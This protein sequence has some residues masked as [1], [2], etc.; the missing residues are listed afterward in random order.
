[1]CRRTSTWRNGRRSR[2]SPRRSYVHRTRPTRRRNI[3]WRPRLHLCRSRWL[4]LNR[5]RRHRRSWLRRRNI[6]RRRTILRRRRMHG[7]ERRTRMVITRTV[8]H[9]AVIAP[10]VVHRARNIRNAVTIRRRVRAAARIDL[11]GIVSTVLRTPLD[12]ATSEQ[13]QRGSQSRRNSQ[14]RHHVRTLAPH[15]GPINHRCG[16]TTPNPQ[17]ERGHA[18]VNNARKRAT[19]TCNAAPRSVGMVWYGRSTIK[20]PS[21]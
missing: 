10:S 2:S 4:H 11:R 17:T 21:Q 9:T 12:H 7:H 13:E 15:P 3:R 14:P 19:V 18:R 16:T 5:L 6:R 8:V 1:M 20:L